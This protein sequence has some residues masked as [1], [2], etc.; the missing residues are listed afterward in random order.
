[1]KTILLTFILTLS[2]GFTQAQCIENVS[3]FGNNTSISSYN[4]SGNVNVTLNTNNTTTLKFENNFQTAPG[5][6]VRVYLI[7]SKNKSSAE[8]KNIVTNVNG[9][10][11]FNDGS[12]VD[13]LEFG[14]IQFSG[15]QNYTIEIP[16]NKDVSNYD[17]VFF[18]CLRFNQFWDYGSFNSFT[19]AS[20][21]VLSV[22]D[23]TVNTSS[24]YPNP[25]QDQFEITNFNSTSSN[26][27]IYNV[28]G[29]QVLYQENKKTIDVS[30]LKAGSYIVKISTDN[31]TSTQKLIIK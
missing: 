7:D 20:C 14:L 22:N 3:N 9:D 5:P 17:T 24:I 13:N 15:A 27:R 31:T 16:A 18:F 1:M 19:D 29:E 10:L 28:L 23:L 11:I 21:A 6:D 8:I 2:F 12:L 30:G 26:I 25:A 4:I